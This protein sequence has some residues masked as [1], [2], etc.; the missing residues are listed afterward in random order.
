[1]AIWSWLKKPAVEAKPIKLENIPTDTIIIRR[2]EDG[3]IIDVVNDKGLTLSHQD[4]H[5]WVQKIGTFYANITEGEI[6]TRRERA[7]EMHIDDIIASLE[8]EYEMREIKREAERQELLISMQKRRETTYPTPIKKQPERK[9]QPSATLDVSHV[10]TAPPQSRSMDSGYVYVMRAGPHCKIGKSVNP[11]SRLNSI[12]TSTAEKVELLRTIPTD[13]MGQ[14]EG[15]L[16][17]KFINRHVRGEWFALTE[18]DI[19]WL[20]ETKLGAEVANNS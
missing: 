9:H 19:K 3:S 2:L 12:Q 17:A 14:L 4:I 1:M 11:K 5:L 20:L 10:H 18:S 6:R 16:Q 15:A 13:A 7:V 8:H